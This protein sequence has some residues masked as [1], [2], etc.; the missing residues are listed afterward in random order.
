MASVSTFRP[1]RLAVLVE[2]DF[3]V[4]DVIAAV[5]VGDEGFRAI[6][7]PL[8][9]TPEFFR[10][11]G[12]Q[13]FLGI[14]EDL[15]AEATADIGRI[16]AQL[17]LGDAQHEGAHEQANDVRVLAGGDERVVLGRLVIEADSRARLHGIGDETL[18]D[19]IDLGDVLGLGEGR[20][21]RRLVAQFPIIALV[22]GGLVVHGRA[23]LECGL[24]VDDGRQLRI[25][26][27]DQFGGVAGLREGLGDDGD[28]GIAD[29][30]RLAF[31]QDRMLGLDHR[32]GVLAGDE[33]A[34]RQAV[35]LVVGQILVR[36]AGDDTGRLAGRR[37]VDA[38]DLGVRDRRAQQIHIGLAGLVDVVGVL[39]DAFEKARV[40]AP[41]GRG[42]DVLG[43]HEGS[44][45]S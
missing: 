42:A 38:V 10:A 20:V 11:P 40:L 16:D 5:R 7:D 37:Q 18:I 19:Q 22:V 33:P 35:D 32:L 3:G 14:V 23:A 24:H 34:A 13:C 45:K 25:V 36:E 39:A 26:D 43:G 17:V 4:R 28:D 8:D 27:G 44:P 15:G 29:V 6:R 2:G 21:R 30:P 9:R 41:L 31:G 1:K 12:D